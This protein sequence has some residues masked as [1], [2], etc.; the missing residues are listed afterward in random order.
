M[1]VP[2]ESALMLAMQ[3]DT[4]LFDKAFKQKI[5]LVSPTTLL[6]ALKAIESSWRYEKQA[7]NISEVYD[8]ALKL[9]EK[10]EIFVSTLEGVGKAIKSADKSYEKA[11]AQLSSGSGNVLR[12]V[13]MLKNV[14]QIKPK[15]LIKGLDDD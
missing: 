4:E 2:I 5:V 9:Y 1:F 13:E 8:R 6:V 7:K 3:N 10:L 15:K 11:F 12:Q 14:S